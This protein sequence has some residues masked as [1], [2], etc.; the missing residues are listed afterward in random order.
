MPDWTYECEWSAYIWFGLCALC[1]G[2][3]L[4]SLLA[5]VSLLH[6]HY[7]L[8]GVWLWLVLGP[9]A[10]QQPLRVRRW[11]QALAAGAVVAALTL[12]A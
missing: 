1:Q 3:G 9:L 5:A 12:H 6:Q 11:L 10:R 2:A 7:F 4:Y 8:A